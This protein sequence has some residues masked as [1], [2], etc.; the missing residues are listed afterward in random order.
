MHPHPF[1]YSI[2]PLLP[3][4]LRNNLKGIRARWILNSSHNHWPIKES[5]ATPPSGW[6]GWPENKQFAFV[7]THDVESQ[8]G[9][10]RVRPLAELEISL[11]FRSCFYFVPEGQ[12]RVPD[13]L[14]FWLVDNGFEVGIHG[15][16]HDGKLYASFE[17]FSKRAGRINAYLKQWKAVGFR[18]P[19]MHHN[20]E[21]LKQLDVEYDSSTFDTDPFEPQPDN[22]STIFPFLVSSALNS[23][24][25]FVELPYTL[26]QDFTLFL[27]LRER[28]CDIWKN[29]LD[30]IAD[31]NGMSLVD[32][33]PDYISFPS[34][35]F[36]NHGYDLSLYSEFLSYV[37]SRYKDQ[38]WHVLPKD[39]ASW[40]RTKDSKRSVEPVAA[41]GRKAV[42]PKIWID[43][44]NT[45][46]VPFFQPIIHE[47]EK[48][49]HE[50]LLTA[51]DAFQV[52]DLAD[53]KG[54]RYIRV[55]RHHGK[56]RFLKF[57]GLFY[58][59]GQLAL[60]VIKEKPQIALSHGSRSQMILCKFLGIPSIAIADYEYVKTIPFFGPR[61]EIVPEVVCSKDLPTRPDHVKTYSGI[62]EDVYAW[63]LT[64][65]PSI[66]QIL[67]INNGSIVVTVR[68][69]ATEAHYHNPQ[70]ESLLIAF[71]N[72]AVNTPD[73]RIVLLPRNSR[74]AEYLRQ[75]YPEWFADNKTV[76][77]S[78]AL[79]GLNLLWHSDL[80]VSG[81]GTMNREAAALGVPVYSIFRGKTGA[82]DQQLRRQGR[83]TLIENADQ[84]ESLIKIQHRSNN[85]HFPNQGSK[86]LNQIL[87]HVDAIANSSCA[88]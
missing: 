15:L 48:R 65:D 82:V 69:P 6:T 31:N 44:D 50:I 25:G 3:E 14:R 5:A 68:P 35:E 49:G 83:L 1:Y 67:G 9:L 85:Q 43:L 81:G 51:R 38:Y 7:L 19:F 42:R 39:L 2:K 73:A 4:R 58:R 53:Q 66:L 26:A 80:V 61:W 76:I 36:R 10:D 84:T 86:A 78:N 72:R 62:K 79:D 41:T 46:H 20:L 22:V 70:S 64:P 77:P 54:M 34:A 60:I 87:D 18:S 47:L 88:V 75:T 21:W 37:A 13:E 40:F 52:C 16:H 28:T 11:G 33:H 71:M 74:Q 63:T 32:V 17:A 12:Y 8:Q 27:L 24:R 29:K 30:W 57:S 59:A 45:P 55:G 23:G 56:N